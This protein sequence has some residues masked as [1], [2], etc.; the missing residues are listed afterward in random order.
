MIADVLTKA[1]PGPT[2]AK[3]ANN[4]TST[5][6]NRQEGVLNKVNLIIPSDEERKF[7][8]EM[9]DHDLAV[10]KHDQGPIPNRYNS[11]STDRT[12]TCRLHNQTLKTK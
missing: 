9:E 12:G 2:F 5:L 8:T 4:L 1:L 11:D 6:N 3:H 10:D 7:L